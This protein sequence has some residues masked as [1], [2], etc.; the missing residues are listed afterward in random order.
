MVSSAEGLAENQVCAYQRFDR[1]TL[2][3]LNEET[4]IRVAE[5]EPLLWRVSGRTVLDLGCNG[6]L[7]SLLA[8]RSGA[9][10]VDAVDVDAELIARL[11]V[12][13]TELGLPVNAEVV[14]FWEIKPS[15]KADVVLAFE[16]VHWLVDQGAE[17]KSIANRLYE[18]TGQIL[19]IETPWDSSE[20]SIAAVGHID[21]KKYS[22]RDLI[23]ALL[24]T[25]FEVRVLHFSQ[26][27]RGDS[28]RVMLEARVIK[29]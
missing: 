25:G 11:Q 24:T 22:A 15:R 16:I 29:L 6:G 17:L 14:P 9:L 2:A 10:R 27:F 4:I 19:L 23:E 3:A 5:L 7:S 18:L 8:A 1:L 20:P 21:E 13:A 26:Y 28:K 12:T